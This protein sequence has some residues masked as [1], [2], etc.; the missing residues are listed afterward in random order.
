[1][2][3][4]YGQE[5]IDPDP[6]ERVR[7]PVMFQRWSSISFLH[8]SFAPDHIRPLV[9]LPLELDLHDGVAWVSLTPF[10]LEGLRPPFAPPLP[11]LSRSP[12]TNVRTYV[13]GPD[14]RRG[15]WFFSLDIGRLPAVIGARV[16]YSLP[17]MWSDVAMSIEGNRIRY[18]GRRRLPRGPAAYR[19]VVRR[20]ERYAETALSSLDHWLTA[21]FSLFSA[22]RGRLLSVSAEHPRWP[23]WKARAE[24]VEESLLQAGNVPSAA[25]PPLVHV[26]TGVD[27][28]IGPSRIV[29]RISSPT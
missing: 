29:G 1:M 10:L 23:L 11:W 20:G 15:I 28:R 3:C 18:S 24:E 27:V 12:E 8:W 4:A 2:T 21:R 14:G 13:R 26:S 9:P 6:P 5:P 7:R 19:V 22:Y 17:Y 16:G 25:G